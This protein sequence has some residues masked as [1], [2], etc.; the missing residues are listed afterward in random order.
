MPLEA[1]ALGCIPGRFG[2]VEVG[3]DDV[4]FFPQVGTGTY[5]DGGIANTACADCGDEKWVAGVE[6]LEG[7]CI[8]AVAEVEVDVGFVAEEEGS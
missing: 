4:P 3:A 7:R 1:S 6:G 8:V 2:D 5:D